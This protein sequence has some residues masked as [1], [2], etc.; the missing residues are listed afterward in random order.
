[1]KCLL[2][3]IE[4]GSIGAGGKRLW[5][6]DAVVLTIGSCRG[7][8]WIFWKCRR[9]DFSSRATNFLPIFWLLWP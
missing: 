8:F 9:S 1:M 4:S 5:K 6:V 2:R 7:S 3:L